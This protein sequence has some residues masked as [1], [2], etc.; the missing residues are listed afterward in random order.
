MNKKA[1]KKA[2]VIGGLK[3]FMWKLFFVLGAITSFRTGY[4]YS[5]FFYFLS[6]PFLLILWMLFHSDFR[7]YLKYCK[8]E[9]FMSNGSHTVFLKNNAK[10]IVNLL[11]GKRHGSFIQYYSNGQIKND[12]NYLEGK[13]NGPN[14]TFYKNGNKYRTLYFNEVGNTEDVKEYFKNGNLKFV[15]NDNTHTFYDEAKNI[16]C[17]VEIECVSRG[18]GELNYYLFKGS[19]KSYSI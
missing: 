4:Y 3:T 16:K 5:N 8:N 15:L 13:L 9:K 6:I 11:D 17:E 10:H 18:E 1:L 2:L 14:F 7:D 12:F 19:W